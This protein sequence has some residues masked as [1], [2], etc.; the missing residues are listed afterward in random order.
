MLFRSPRNEDEVSAGALTIGGSAWAQH[1]GIERVEV[2]L[3]GGAWAAARLGSV[4]NADTWVQWAFDAQIDPGEHVVRVRAVD[5]VGEIQTD[6]VADVVPDGA[7]GLHEV[8]FT[9]G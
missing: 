6:V 1:T 3:D 9:A 7:T 5:A 4:P 2:S 8:H